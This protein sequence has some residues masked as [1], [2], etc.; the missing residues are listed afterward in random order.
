M[1]TTQ[2]IARIIGTDATEPALTPRQ[3]LRTAQSAVNAARAELDVLRVTTAFDGEASTSV[4]RAQ[5]AVEAATAALRAS[6]QGTAVAMV[7]RALGT[8]EPFGVPIQE[9][10]AELQRAEDELEG[11]KDAK[12]YLEG[13]IP[14]AERWLQSAGWKVEAAADAVIVAE[15]SP[16]AA[17]IWEEHAR[18]KREAQELDAAVEWL[19]RHDFGKAIGK[20]SH[21]PIPVHDRDAGAR[22]WQSW[23]AALLTDADAVM[24]VIAGVSE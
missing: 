18:V 10:R 14:D 20:G 19:R 21:L 16:H 15:V 2:T 23:K 4:R 6:R 3:V 22:P 24:P 8:P 1:S 11:A 12:R 7:S 9:I 5:D 13:Q 17:K